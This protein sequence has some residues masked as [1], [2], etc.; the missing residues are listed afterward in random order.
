M[1]LN[2]G[3]LPTTTLNDKRV[4]CCPA[5]GNL[6]TWRD[7]G[8]APSDNSGKTSDD[9]LT[10][11]SIHRIQR[12]AAISGTQTFAVL[13]RK[14][15]FHPLLS[16]P[17]Q[18]AFWLDGRHGLVRPTQLHRSISEKRRSIIGRLVFGRLPNS[19]GYFSVDAGGGRMT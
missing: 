6:G 3:N 7:L 11:L 9:Y 16:I 4:R 12:Y 2:V 17:G 15:S 1:L 5:G 13:C 14:Q 10:I 8:Q 19:V 18:N